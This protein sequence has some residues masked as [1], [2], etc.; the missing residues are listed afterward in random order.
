MDSLPPPPRTPPRREHLLR[1]PAPHSVLNPDGPP[2]PLPAPHADTAPPAPPAL[3]PAPLPLPHAD[4]PPPALPPPNAPTTNISLDSMYVLSNHFFNPPP[5]FH[6]PPPAPP[7][8]NVMHVDDDVVDT[9]HREQLT[10][11]S[12]QSD[13]LPIVTTPCISSPFHPIHCKYHKFFR[14][15]SDYVGLDVPPPMYPADF[16][17]DDDYNLSRYCKVPRDM[18]DALWAINTITNEEVVYNHIKQHNCV[19]CGI[20]CS[21][22]SGVLPCVCENCDK[23]FCPRCMGQCFDVERQQCPA[24]R[25]KAQNI[26]SDY[27]LRLTDCVISCVAAWERHNTV[28]FVNSLGFMYIKSLSGRDSMWTCAEQSAFQ[29]SSASKSHNNYYCFEARRQSLVYPF[30]TGPEV[31][32]SVT[33]RFQNNI[34]IK[35]CS[36]FPTK[37]YESGRES[38]Y[39]VGKFI[40]LYHE[41]CQ[42]NMRDPFSIHKIWKRGAMR[43]DE[44]HSRWKEYDPLGLHGICCHVSTT[45]FRC[46]F[47]AGWETKAGK[48]NKTYATQFGPDEIFRFSSTES[49]C[50]QKAEQQKQYVR[51]VL[52]AAQVHNI[53]VDDDF[54]GPNFERLVVNG[55]LYPHNDFLM[56]H[57]DIQNEYGFHT[58]LIC[59][60]TMGQETNRVW[61]DDAQVWINRDPAM[62]LCWSV[63]NGRIPVWEGMGTN[64]KP[65]DAVLMTRPGTQENMHAVPPV[66]STIYNA[67]YRKANDKCGVDKW[68]AK[69][70][71][72]KAVKQMHKKRRKNRTL[73][74]AG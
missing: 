34:N 30:E 70:K 4:T 31:L 21:A 66:V 40:P 38:E 63:R 10:H 49:L 6:V 65:G 9:P 71:K 69:N 5:H 67:Q 55:L 60:F 16:R 18:V 27:H 8:D 64:R 53:D 24:C 12:F 25:L 11:T 74:A 46:M 37:K 20:E 43:D 2:S 35:I 58:K 45:S 59:T 51:R 62:A 19:V 36:L 14:P 3:P 29:Q 68:V 39:R 1:L 22:M 48:K 28:F 26:K 57:K 32:E 73:F 50:R 17:V 7:T 33:Y 61:D 44:F 23:P 54:Y 56:S 13:H 47:G 52:V 41:F 72:Q 42:K 15:A